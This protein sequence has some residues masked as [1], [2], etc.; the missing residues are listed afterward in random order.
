[1]P[2]SPAIEVKNLTIRFGDFTAVDDVSFAMERNAAV[3]IIGPNGAGKTTFVSLLTGQFSPTSGTVKLFGHDVTKTSAARRVTMGVLRSFQ[4]V[5]VFDNL[6]VHENIALALYKKEAK[7]H[8]LSA[9]FFHTL[10]RKGYKEKVDEVR[11]LFHLSQVR[12]ELVSSL[13]LGNKKKLEI[14]MIY[15]TDP[16]LMILDEPFAGLGDQEIDEVLL[17]LKKCVHKKTLLI[18]EH[19]LSKLTAVVDKLA[20]MHEGRLIAYGPC[21]ETL[22]NP[23][24]RKSYWKLTEC[25]A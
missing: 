19:K 16:E 4:L 13:S 1:M 14:A 10:F 21:E 12:N 25:E 20:V 15:I 6:T 24:V 18:V 8:A 22:Q 23:E 17:V 2:V 11:R 9:G 3:G 7:G 5:Q